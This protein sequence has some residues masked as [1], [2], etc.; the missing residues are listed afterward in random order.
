MSSNIPKAFSWLLCYIHSPVAWRKLTHKLFM[1]GLLY[2]SAI[3]AKRNNLKPTSEQQ[4]Q[5]HHLVQSMAIM[6]NKERRMHI[7]KIIYN[8]LGL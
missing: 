2:A 4:D 6:T 7:L 5:H 1:M 8:K 3:S